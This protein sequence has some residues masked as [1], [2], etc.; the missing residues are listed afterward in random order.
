[1]HYSCFS[2]TACISQKSVEIEGMFAER[3][4]PELYLINEVVAMHA[5]TVLP[6]ACMAVVVATTRYGE[7]H[8]LNSITTIN[9]SSYLLHVQS[10]TARQVSF[11]S[12]M[13]FCEIE[14]YRNVGEK[15][16]SIAGVCKH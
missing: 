1:M 9:D 10:C 12:I 15:M 14:S 16:E 4:K 13:A 11:L 8:F 6:P 5:R 3:K 7:I 2:I